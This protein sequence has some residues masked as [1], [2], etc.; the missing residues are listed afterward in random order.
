M[1]IGVHGLIL[2]TPLTLEE[3]ELNRE[4]ISANPAYPE[5]PRQFR[6]C[7]GI[8]RKCFFDNV[9]FWEIAQY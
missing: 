4:L 3:L 5:M 2:E 7:L 1:E 6:K 9:H 8:C